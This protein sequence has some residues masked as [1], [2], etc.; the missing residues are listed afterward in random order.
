MSG[1]VDLNIKLQA[2]KIKLSEME[3]QAKRLKDKISFAEEILK[4]EDE[5]LKISLHSDVSYTEASQVSLP[6]S[7]KG[8]FVDSAMSLTN[9]NIFTHLKAKG[10][11]YKIP[12][13]YATLSKLKTKG[14][15][16][17]VN[18]GGTKKFRLRKNDAGL[19][20]ES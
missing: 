9:E 6:E 2:W 1:V 3:A 16:E 20:L 5:G 8:L 11:K 12:S 14:I 17:V 19:Q 13:V 10:I 18:E 4:E 7:I 15:I